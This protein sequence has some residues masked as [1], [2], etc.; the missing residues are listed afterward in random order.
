M[1]VV[2]SVPSLALH[3]PDA[4]QDDVLS[5]MAMPGQSLRNVV[6]IPLDQPPPGLYWYHTH[7]DGE[8]YQQDRE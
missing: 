6:D 4:P 8:S 2:P 5:M 1:V 7:P 3:S